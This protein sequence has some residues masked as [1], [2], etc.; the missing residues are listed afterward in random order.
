M[1]DHEM[2]DYLR[3]RPFRKIAWRHGFEHGEYA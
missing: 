3:P 1:F 2:T